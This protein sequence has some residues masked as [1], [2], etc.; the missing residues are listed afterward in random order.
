MRSISTNLD[1]L[2]DPK[3]LRDLEWYSHVTQWDI[4]A[5]FG[6]DPF[7]VTPMDIKLEKLSRGRSPRLLSSHMAASVALLGLKQ[8]GHRKLRGAIFRGSKGHPVCAYGVVKVTTS[9]SSFGIFIPA[10]A[11]RRIGH[12][13][14]AQAGWLPPSGGNDDNL[15]VPKWALAMAAFCQNICD[16]DWCG[17]AAITPYNNVTQY[18]VQVDRDQ[19]AKLVRM[20]AEWMGTHL[21]LTD[22]KAV[23]AGEMPTVDVG[24]ELPA[25]GDMLARAEKIRDLDAEIADLAHDRRALSDSLLADLGTARR[26]LHPSTGRVVAEVVRPHRLWRMASPSPSHFAEMKVSQHCVPVPQQVSLEVHGSP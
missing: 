24:G 21:A 26:L 18:V 19:G 11:P 2:L 15:R 16:A 23:A 25:S 14:A 10:Y 7:G 6:V 5:I 13:E 9:P 22:S 8:L 1:S 12:A 3:V 20:A 17:I 4:P